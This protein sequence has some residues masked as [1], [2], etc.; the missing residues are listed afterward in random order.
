MRLSPTVRLAS[1]VPVWRRPV[2]EKREREIVLADFLQQFLQSA[3][4]DLNQVVE[5]EHEGANRIGQGLALLGDLGHDS[6]LA[7]L[8]HT[9][10]D[11][12]HHL[13]TADALPA[14]PFAGQ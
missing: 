4:I 14:Q 9:R 8:V 6:A 10:E 2:H 1:G 5:D 3:V 7:G 13:G 12:G 11:V